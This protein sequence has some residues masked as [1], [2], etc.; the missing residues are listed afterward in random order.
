VKHIEKLIR[1]VEGLS[2]ELEKSKAIEAKVEIKMNEAELKVSKI[3]DKLLEAEAN[4]LAKTSKVKNLAEEQTRTKERERT[5][6]TSRSSTNVKT[7][8]S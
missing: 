2:F 8:S 3:E 1:H 6:F 5:I 7:N 4:Y